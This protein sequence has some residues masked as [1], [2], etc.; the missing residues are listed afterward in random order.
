M[1]V[2]D[3]GSHRSDTFSVTQLTVIFAYKHYFFPSAK[4]K[5]TDW[6]AVDQ[7]SA[8]WLKVAKGIVSQTFNVE[9]IS[10]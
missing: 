10:P 4:L 7:S 9:N 6:S 3:G 2:N 5:V 1:A 8:G